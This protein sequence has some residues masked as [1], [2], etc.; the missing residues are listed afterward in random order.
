VRAIVIDAPGAVGLRELTAPVAGPSEVV[1]RSRAAGV[2][3]TDLEVLRGELDSRW[4]R[5]PCVPGHEWSGEIADVGESVTGLAVGDRVVCEGIIPCGRCR[6][7]AA[8]DTNLCEHYDQLGFTRPGGYAELVRVPARVVHRLPDHV[9]FEAGVLVEPASV[10]L[11]ALERGRLAAGEAVGVVGVGTIGSLSIVLARL[12][13]PSRIVAYGIRPEELELALRLGVD[14]AVDVS[15]VEPPLRELDVVFETAGAVPAVE[16]GTRLV[17]DGGRV[18]MLGIAP[19]GKTLDSVPANRFSLRDLELIGS[20]S[21]TSAA[22]ARVVS[23]LADR[24]VDLLPIVTH[25]FPLEDFERAFD[26][27]EARNGTVAKIVLELD[28]A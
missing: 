14:E 10:V 26:L 28:P 22:W 12:F 13:Q 21:Y 25:R 2:C 17:S 18:V 15:A 9:S 3:R 16:L 11:R 27:L 6:R 5:Y 19:E 24:R 1:V 4:V 20:F 23:L 7:C 8:G